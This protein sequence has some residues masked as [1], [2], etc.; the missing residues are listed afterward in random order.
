M[1]CIICGAEFPDS[2]VSLPVKD[3]EQPKYFPKEVC[4]GCADMNNSRK[5]AVK[6]NCD[7]PPT[8]MPYI[9]LA[10]R[11]E[12][13]I[14]REYEG[15]YM[16]ALEALNDPR[17]IANLCTEE[18]RAFLR[19]HNMVSTSGYHDALT[20][21]RINDLLDSVRRDVQKKFPRIEGDCLAMIRK[22]YGLYKLVCDA[23]ET[24]EQYQ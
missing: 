5:P 10:G 12:N 8:V 22:R 17:N 24:R 16:E 3:D 9:R 2:I 6:R 20:F 7:N 23:L 18:E 14:L 1:K 13:L 11:I 19:Y 21:G 15:Y 4:D